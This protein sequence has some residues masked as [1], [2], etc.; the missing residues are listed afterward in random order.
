MVPKLSLDPEL[1]RYLVES[2]LICDSVARDRRIDTA[3]VY[4]EDDEISDPHLLPAATKATYGARG[5]LVNTL[6]K[7]RPQMY[8]YNSGASSPVNMR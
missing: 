5:N 7:L 1:Q 6:T 3:C 4:D 8:D 2:G